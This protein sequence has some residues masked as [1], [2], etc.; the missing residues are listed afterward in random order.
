MAFVEDPVTEGRGG[1]MIRDM[2]Y[3][4]RDFLQGEFNNSE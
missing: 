3:T 2:Q 1:D 4:E